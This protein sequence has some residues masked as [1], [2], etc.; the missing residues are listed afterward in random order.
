MSLLLR[1]MH[2]YLALFLTPWVL[3]YTAST[4]VMNHRTLF[5]GPPPQQPPKF[6]LERELI[7]DGEL[8]EGATPQQVAVQLLGALGMDGTHTLG[9][10]APAGTVVINRQ[11]AV[12]PRRI[13]YTA[14]DRKVRVEKMVFQGAGFLERMHRRRG[15]Q[16][17][18]LVEDA[19][20]LS[21]DVTIGALLLLAGSGIWMWWELRAARRWG[22]LAL[23]GGCGL[24]A[25]FLGVM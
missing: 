11:H 12:A 17:P 5:H 14:A 2:L 8:P 23:A 10:G 6:E 7:Y 15:F 9:R 21:V 1:R 4:F 16:H 18:Y 24:F 25:V 20:A 19:W 22:A 13:T 3:M